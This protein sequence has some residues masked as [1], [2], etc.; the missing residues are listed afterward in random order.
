MWKKS[1]GWEPQDRRRWTGGLHVC[2]GPH[3]RPW[4]QISVE[5]STLHGA[6]WS[7]PKRPEAE[8]AKRRCFYEKER[9]RIDRCR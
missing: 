2:E 3:R 6:Q 7:G 1:R 5:I 8:T 4:I 9:K